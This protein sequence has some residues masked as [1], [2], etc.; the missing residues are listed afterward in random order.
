M[1]FKTLTKADTCFAE[2]PLN[3]RTRE[4]RDFSLSI[5]ILKSHY[6]IVYFFS[7]GKVIFGADHNNW[8]DGVDECFSTRLK[9]TTPMNKAMSMK[10]ALHP[11]PAQAA[12]PTPR[13]PARN[14]SIM[15]VM[16]LMAAT[17]CQPSGIDETG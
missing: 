16:G 17:H 2:N 7:R 6:R 13:K 5:E 14:V 8:L 15:G 12:L 3:L 11:S 4:Y 9:I 10:P 1:D